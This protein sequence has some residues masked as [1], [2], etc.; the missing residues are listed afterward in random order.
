MKE[1]NLWLAEVVQLYWLIY[2][3]I[4]TSNLWKNNPQHYYRN[5]LTP[6]SSLQIPAESTSYTAYDYEQNTWYLTDQLENLHCTTIVGNYLNTNYHPRYCRSR[7]YK[8]YS[9]SQNFHYPKTW[10]Y[11]LNLKFK[12][13]NDAN[14]E[15]GYVLLQHWCIWES[16]PE[17]FQNCLHA[18]DVRNN[19]QILAVELDVDTTGWITAAI[20]RMN[21]TIPLLA[22]ESLEISS[23]T[24]SRHRHLTLCNLIIPI[25][26]LIIYPHTIAHWSLSFPNP[27]LFY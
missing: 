23:R 17:L 19:I 5:L 4:S 26:S 25:T 24:T 7:S 20:P 1:R 10:S 21:L 9:Y 2:D 13:R 15:I 12:S 6:S 3:S 27:N 14:Q 16:N 11:Y 8:K 22:T 18:V